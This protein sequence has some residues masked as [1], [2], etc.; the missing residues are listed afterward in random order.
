MGHCH[1]PIDAGQESKQGSGKAVA[2]A[3]EAE[4]HILIP[5]CPFTFPAVFFVLFFILHQGNMKKKW[6]NYGY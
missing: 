4:Q 1:L 6:E 2:A 3:R 5:F